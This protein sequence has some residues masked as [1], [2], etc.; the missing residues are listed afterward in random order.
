MLHSFFILS[1]GLLLGCS[2]PEAAVYSAPPGD[3]VKVSSVNTLALIG[4]VNR[5]EKEI[6][7]FEMRDHEMGFAKNGQLFIGSSSI[8]LWKDCVH[9]CED[10][11]GINRGFGGATIAEI[12]HYFPRIVA[13]YEPKTVFFYCGENDLAHPKASVDSVFSDFKKF[14]MKL[15]Q[16]SPQTKLVYLS[17]KNSP[18]RMQYAD[19]FM[20]MNQLVKD[21]GS[22]DDRFYYVDFNSP[23]LNEQGKPDSLLFKKDMLHLNE[24]G[25]KKWEKVLLPV[26]QET[27][28]AY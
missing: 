6:M 13:K 26:I 1:M 19:K 2:A 17:I 15:H 27:T 7:A 3:S 4:N 28:K 10:N 18:S 22:K 23:L 5:F 11:T 24:N 14:A 20:Q 25:Y 12:N 21:W 9:Y 16:L 8:R